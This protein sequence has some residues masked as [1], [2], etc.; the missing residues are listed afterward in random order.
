LLDERAQVIGGFL[1]RE[2]LIRKFNYAISNCESDSL[3]AKEDLGTMPPSRDFIFLRVALLQ[4]LLDPGN[5]SLRE[6]QGGFP[7][8]ATRYGDSS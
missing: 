5:V 2:G 4:L 6:I 8:T 1:Y 3:P 7:R